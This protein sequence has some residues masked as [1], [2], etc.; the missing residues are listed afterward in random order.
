MSVETIW[1]SISRT[2]VRPDPWDLLARAGG[3]LP[4]ALTAAAMVV[5]GFGLAAVPAVVAH[6]LAMPLA[7]WLG[8]GASVAQAPGALAALG[9][10][11]LGTALAA[12]VLHRQHARP[13][14]YAH[15]EARYAYTFTGRRRM[16]GG[17]LAAYLTAAT[18]AAGV[19]EATGASAGLWKLLAY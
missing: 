18:L 8:V 1:P 7:A 14:A 15:G 11:A 16:A 17:L 6:G 12:Q 2:P 5:A 10:L 9:G 13:L 19:A 4:P 3:S